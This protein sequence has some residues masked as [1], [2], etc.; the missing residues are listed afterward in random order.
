M[1]NALRSLCAHKKKNTFSFK[2]LISTLA[3]ELEC[4]FKEMKAQINI[5]AEK[6]P[7]FITIFPPEF[8]VNTHTIRINMY[9]PFPSLSEKIKTLTDE[10][11]EFE[12]IHFTN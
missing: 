11:H 7:E 4:T 1:C 2:E 8:Y 3:S 5:L 9:T 12:L 6:I 10:S